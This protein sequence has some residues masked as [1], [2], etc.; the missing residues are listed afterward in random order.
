MSD[1]TLSSDRPNSSEIHGGVDEP[2][3]SVVIASVNG[4]PY[5]TDCL[6]AL[7]QAKGP[8]SCE[9]LVVDCCDASTRAEIRARFPYPEL[10]LIEVQG[11]PSIP[12]LRAMGVER[13]RGRMIALLEDHCDVQPGWFEAIARACEAGYRVVGGPV[14][15][16]SRERLIDW[17]VFFCEYAKFMPPLPRG[18][19][20]EIAGNNSAY[21]RDFLAPLVAESGEVLEFFLHQAMRERGAAFFCDPDMI[22]SHRKQFSYGYFLSQRYHYSRAFAGMRMQGKPV[23]RRMAY[24][25]ATPLLPGLLLV[26]LMQTVLRKPG[27]SR[28][29]L[30]T[31]PAIVTFLVP[32]AWGEA[33]GALLG[34]GRSAERIE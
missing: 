1:A 26:R 4:L 16:G 28:E 3:V 32:W 33:V 10:Q 12:R 31:L 6:A 2:L 24:A 25:C 7:R 11:R 30:K 9:I 29:F 19:V 14:E 8:V 22:V 18:E 5:I 15:N 13:A 20:V 27:Y 34:P 21:D 23:S 17:A